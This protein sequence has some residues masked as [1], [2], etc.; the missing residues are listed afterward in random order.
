MMASVAASLLSFQLLFASVTI[1]TYICQT[2]VVPVISSPV[3]NEIVYSA[4]PIVVNGTASADTNV[5]LSDNGQVYANVTA[6]QYNKFSALVYLS[7]GGH[8]LG[9]TTTNPCGT[10]TGIPVNIS[11][12]A[13]PVPPPTPTEPS[14]PPVEPHPGDEP[15]MVPPADPAAPEASLPDNAN[16][17]K[18]K[19]PAKD[20][21]KNNKKSSGQDA[22][23][24]SD[25]Y[26]KNGYVTNNASI[27]LTG[28]MSKP[29]TVEIIVNDR[30]V[31]SILRDQASF[32]ASIPLS[33]G[34][35]TLTITAKSGKE[36]VSEVLNITRNEKTP[37]IETITTLEWYQTA[38]GQAIIASIILL[39]I[40]ICLIIL[41]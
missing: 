4:T 1:Q 21:K 17:D 2:P 7:E 10:S 38:S 14:E 5:A 16:T 12:E 35:N 30:V 25:I 36:Q 19:S 18:P 27:Y 32:G 31:A 34:D 33:V 20:K 6:D 15:P 13:K 26:P 29:A 37:E 9:V 28:N 39:I 24:M 22:L 11:A 41:L 40:L 23:I 3:E 8:E